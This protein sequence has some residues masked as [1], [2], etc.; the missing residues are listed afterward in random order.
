[1]IKNVWG[2]C[3]LNLSFDRSTFTLLPP[4]VV[5]LQFNWNSSP[6]CT[7]NV[8]CRQLKP[9]FFHTK[10]H[11]CAITLHR[12][13]LA[14]KLDP[15]FTLKKKKGDNNHSNTGTTGGWS[16]SQLKPHHICMLCKTLR[17]RVCVHTTEIEKYYGQP[18]FTMSRKRKR[19]TPEVKTMSTFKL[20][21]NLIS[22]K[23]S[24]FSLKV[25]PMTLLF[26]RNLSKN[27][28]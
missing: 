19:L 15:H 25:H 10:Q 22:T 20:L 18:P 7:R 17:A 16:H 28:L 24:M 21:R 4:Y 5:Y 12:V 6:F 8:A 1:M 23:Q 27:T 3:A 2:K 11:P 14:N 26:P 9:L 13:I